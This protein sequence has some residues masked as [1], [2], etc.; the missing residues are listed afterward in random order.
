MHRP[1]EVLEDLVRAGRIRLADREVVDTGP[2]SGEI[3]DHDP[4]LT[5]EELFDLAMGDVDALGWSAADPPAAPPFEIQSGDDEAEALRLLEEFTR[6]GRVAPEHS[7]EYDEH[8][9]HPTGKLYLSDL[10]SGRFAIQAHPDLHGMTIEGARATVEAFFQESIRA[11]FRCVRVVHG[12][13]RHS[14][15]R[16][17]AMKENLQKWMRERRLGRYV[18][19]F[20]TARQMD[21]G[22]GAIYVLLRSE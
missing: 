21:G 6:E 16:H 18:I 1:F 14:P 5:D 20:T 3:L 7:R 15:D 10:R 13:G 4:D 12:R 8:S 9:A 11:G 19:A 2:A 17:P 22:G